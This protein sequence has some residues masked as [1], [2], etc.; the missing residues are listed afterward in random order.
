MPDGSGDADNGRWFYRRVFASHYDELEDAT[1]PE[2]FEPRPKEKKAGVGPTIYLRDL[3]SAEDVLAGHC[4][5]KNGFRMH[6][7]EFPE[8]AIPEGFRAEPTFDDPAHF[9]LMGDIYAETEPQ[10]QWAGPIAEQC[11]LVLR[12]DNGT[13]TNMKDGSKVIISAEMHKG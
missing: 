9:S 12:C 4:P 3:R 1:G 7:V 11:S 10:Y 8:S 5:H 6:V 2:A 13:A